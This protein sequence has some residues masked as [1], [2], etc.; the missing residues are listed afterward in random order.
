MTTKILSGLRL[1]QV[2]GIA[3][4]GTALL[5]AG[6]DTD[7]L[8]EVVDSENVTPAT[9]DNPDLIDVV[10][11][12][13]IGEFTTAYAGSGGDAFL[14]SVGVFTD[15]FFSL[16]QTKPASPIKPCCRADPN[17]ILGTFLY[18]VCLKLIIFEVNC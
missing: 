16:N 1:G 11:A 14:S 2:F 5:F 4:M 6:C 10:Y 18:A 9:L 17:P 15:E 8:L 7:E 13:A 3:I 12:G